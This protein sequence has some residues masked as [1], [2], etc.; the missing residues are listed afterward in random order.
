MNQG[1]IYISSGILTEKEDEV[2]RVIKSCGFDIIETR[3]DGMWCAIAARARFWWLPASTENND[4][5]SER[6]CPDT[7]R[8]FAFAD[9]DQSFL[10]WRILRQVLHPNIMPTTRT[11]AMLTFLTIFE[12]STLTVMSAVFSPLSCKFILFTPLV[13][14]ILSDNFVHVKIRSAQKTL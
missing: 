13:K 7:G 8:P 4:E 10:S 11:P 1:G 2:T 14:S 6:Q 9:L 5:K 12:T 3:K